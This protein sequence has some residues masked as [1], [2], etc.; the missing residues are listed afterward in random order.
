M[1]KGAVVQ[2]TRGRVLI[3]WQQYTYALKTPGD[4]DILSGR[5]SSRVLSIS[6]VDIIYETQHSMVGSYRP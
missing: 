3:L 2:C 4:A 5:E 6:T 1:S